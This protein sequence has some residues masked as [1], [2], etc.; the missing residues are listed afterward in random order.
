MECRHCG[1]ENTDQARFCQACGKSFA[2]ESKSCGNCGAVN[3]GTAVYCINCGKA[4]EPIATPAA[5]WSS[6]GTKVPEE[7][8]TLDPPAAKST[9]SATPSTGDTA[10]HKVAALCIWAV[11]LGGRRDPARGRH[12]FLHELRRRDQCEP[13]RGRPGR[14]RK[15]SPGG[16]HLLCDVHFLCEAGQALLV[17]EI[18]W[19]RLPQVTSPA[20]WCA[21]GASSRLDTQLRTHEPIAQELRTPLLDRMNQRPRAKARFGNSPMLKNRRYLRADSFFRPGRADR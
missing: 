15:K 5:L 6:S 2:P 16:N 21:A 4:L 14:W 13:P 1:A 12:F 11:H 17:E 3:S 10:D 20:T 18:K 19:R 9:R 8:K 7:V